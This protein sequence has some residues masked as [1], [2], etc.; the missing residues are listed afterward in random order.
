ITAGEQLRITPQIATFFARHPGCRLHNHYG[1]TESHVVVAHTLAGEPAAWPVLPP[2]GRPVGNVR[3]YLLD[4]HGAPVAEGVAGEIH[5]GGAQ[6][7][8]GYRNLDALG[9]A[10]FLADPFSGTPGARMYRTGDLGRWR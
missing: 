6:L 3:I 4:A 1:P 8:R 7:A 10:R 5:I 2:I 9:E